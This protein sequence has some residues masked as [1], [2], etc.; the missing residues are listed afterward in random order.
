MNR[1]LGSCGT[2]TEDPTFLSSE[3]QKEMRRTVRLKVFEEMM[4]G[5]LPNLVKNTNQQIQEADQTP[6]RIN[7][8]T[9]IYTKIYHLTLLEN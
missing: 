5:N 7:K 4:P 2:I 3:I 9:K 8:Q 6:S 1:S